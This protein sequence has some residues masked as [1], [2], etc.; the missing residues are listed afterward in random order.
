MGEKRML[1][2]ITRMYANQGNTDDEF[3]QTNFFNQSNSLFHAVFPSEASNQTERIVVVIHG[4][5]GRFNDPENDSE[6]ATELIAQAICGAIISISISLKDFTI[7][8][9]F[10][11]HHEWQNFSDY[12]QKKINN[13]LNNKLNENITIKFVEQYSSAGP[14]E[15]YEKVQELVAPAVQ[16]ADFQNKFDGV[17]DFFGRKAPIK[18][19]EA[20]QRLSLLKHKIVNI[21]LPLQIDIHGLIEKNFDEIYWDQIVEAHK[22]LSQEFQNVKNLIYGTSTSGE[23]EPKSIQDIISK[24]TDDEIK[25]Y[26]KDILENKIKKQLLPENQDK[27]TCNVIVNELVSALANN[28][29]NKFKQIITLH[30]NV[31]KK[32]MDELI[33]CIDQLILE[34]NK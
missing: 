2:I 33:D 24:I 14:Q 23:S 17:W 34:L 20:A 30:G 26:L 15:E 6:Q 7:G 5:N 19:S 9:L 1:I 22:N 32:W 8:I 18:M 25:A 16:E 3:V 29:R 28:D 31:Y 4:Y 13:K 21:L 12:F 27:F 11:P 10:H